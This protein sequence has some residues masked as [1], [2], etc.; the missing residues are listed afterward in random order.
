MDAPGTPT[1]AATRSFVVDRGDEGTRLDVLLTRQL[2]AGRSATRTRV[3]RWVDA[4]KV[5]I[6]GRVTTRPARPVRTGD[7]VDLELP[8]RRTVTDHQPEDIALDVLFEDEHLLIVSKP[9]GMLVHPTGRHRTGTLFNALLWRA[10]TWTD[11]ARPG[12]VHRLDRDTSGV[13]VVARSRLVH[14][15]TVRLLRSG[16]ARKR[17]LAIVAGEPP[18]AGVIRVPLAKVSEAPP[19]MGARED[20]LACETRFEVQARGEGDSAGL[21]L[22]TCDLITGRMHQIRAHLHASGWPIVGD[23][24]YGPAVLDGRVAG[25]VRTAVESLKRQALHAWQLTLPH[26]VTE[27]MIDVTAPVPEDMRGI[28][29]PQPCPPRSRRHAVPPK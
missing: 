25:D 19:R 29:P 15:R 18:D 1:D 7:R 16:R 28:L 5:R 27:D 11:G 13:I 26:P 10:R 9:A 14:A 17:Y 3:Q 12:L 20:G 21:A 4:G 22:V 24:V 23:P 6:N 8:W 2:A